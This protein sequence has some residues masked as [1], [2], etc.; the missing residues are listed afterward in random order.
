MNTHLKPNLKEGKDYVLVGE[1][2]FDF[3]VKKYGIV[4]KI[5]HEIKRFGISVGD[6]NSEEAILELYF[7]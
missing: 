4:D 5:S 1:D 6:E 7:R 2:I 3:L